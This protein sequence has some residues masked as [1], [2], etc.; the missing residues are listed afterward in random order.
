[1]SV[2]T[3]ACNLTLIIKCV[4]TGVH[5]YMPVGEKKIKISVLLSRARNV[6][7]LVLNAPRYLAQLDANPQNTD[8]YSSSQ[9]DELSFPVRLGI[10]VSTR[11]GSSFRGAE[12]RT[13]PPPSLF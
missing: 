12:L 9:C 1:M 13:P 6:C 2:C 8:T 4:F 3:L 11:F 10:L 5:S 7:L